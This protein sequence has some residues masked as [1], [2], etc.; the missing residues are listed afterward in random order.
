MFTRFSK[1]SATIILISLLVTATS[2]ATHARTITRFG[3]EH[4]VLRGVRIK[5]KDGR[6]LAGY[7]G[8]SSEDGKKPKFPQSLI[9]PT[10]YAEGT[11]TLEL[12]TRLYPVSKKVLRRAFSGGIIMGMVIATPSGTLKLPIKQIA[13]IRALRMKYDGIEATIDGMITDVR[14]RTIIRLLI[15]GKPFATLKNDDYGYVLVSFNRQ[16]GRR[17]LAAIN[18][19]EIRL[20]TNGRA[21]SGKAWEQ[22]T[23]RLERQRV[24]AIEFI[25]ED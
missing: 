11:K 1:C 2:S 16:I 12:Y 18:A 10:T 13:T 22:A 21:N 15:S 24:V 6:R 25:T 3:M 5:M 20:R 8:W 19:A 4:A 17:K 23:R 9:D 14:S 7:V